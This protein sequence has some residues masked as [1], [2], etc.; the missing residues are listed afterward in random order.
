MDAASRKV[1]ARMPLA[2]SILTLWCWVADSTYLD[3]LFEQHRG[4]CYTKILSFS[5]IVRIIRDALL[6]HDGSGRKS[7]QHSREQEELET[8]F[9]AAYGKLGRIPIP[10]SSAFL[11]GCT[12]RLVDVFPQT[13]M[14]CA[15]IPTSLASFRPIIFDGKA[16]KRVAKRLLPLRGAAGGLLGGRTL[17]ALDVRTGLAVAMHGHPDG[18]ANDTRF[19]GDLVPTVR[20]LVNGPRLWIVDSGFCDLT[21]TTHFTAEAGDEFI[22]RYHPKVRFDRDPE[23]AVREGRDQRNRLYYEDWGWL[24][25]PRNP[26]RRYV[27]R[28]TLKRPG[29]AD[30]ILVTSLCD[31]EAFPATDVLDLYLKRWSIEQTFQQVTEVFGLSTLIGSTPEG[32]IF[33]FALCLLLY[34]MIQ[35][36]RGVIATAAERPREEISTENLFDDVQRELIAWNVVIQ[37]DDTLS[38]FKGEWTAARVSARL[39]ELLD[40]VWHDRWRKAPPKKKQPPHPNRESKRTHGS[41]FRII[42][43]HRRKTAE[44]RAARTAQ[45]S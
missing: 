35:V 42:E 37:H 15:S 8:S 40:G 28:I 4:R 24:G 25:S 29:E 12:A 1:L 10:L 7:M 6:E 2:E 30:V 9:A 18:D 19:V 26:K 11:S 38:Y 45:R 22:V 41:V 27:R 21:Q 36:V 23:R 31:A 14:A 44:V 32:T 33:Q 20:Q 34:N 43:A 39:T 17:V 3:Q 16:I 13:E 5:L